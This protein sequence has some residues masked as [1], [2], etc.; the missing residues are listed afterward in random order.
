[1]MWWNDG[2]GWGGWIMMTLAMVIFW[3]LL[4][5]GVAAVFRGISEQRPARPGAERDAQQ[6]LDERYARGEID[7]AEYHAR[8]EVLRAAH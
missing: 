4:I 3:A 5:F 6:I 1:M 7:E 8:Q 2:M